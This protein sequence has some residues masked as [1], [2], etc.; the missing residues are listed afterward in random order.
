MKNHTRAY[1]QYCWV[2]GKNVVM[3]ETVFHNGTKAH[4]CKSFAE[5][6]RQGGCRG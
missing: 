6:Q 2:R 4:A 3:E 1:E 5:C